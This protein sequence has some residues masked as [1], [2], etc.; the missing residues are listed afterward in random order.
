[1]NV[2]D[3]GSIHRELCIGQSLLVCI[4]FRGDVLLASSVGARLLILGKDW[5]SASNLGPALWG[6]FGNVRPTC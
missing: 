3:F 5:G 4:S 2:G 6:A 1:M